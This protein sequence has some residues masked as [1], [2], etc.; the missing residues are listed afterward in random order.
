ME[1]WG[2]SGGEAGEEKNRGEACHK[3]ACYEVLALS[4]IAKMGYNTA[5]RAWQRVGWWRLRQRR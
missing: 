1:V 5:K 4:S 2:I 3:M